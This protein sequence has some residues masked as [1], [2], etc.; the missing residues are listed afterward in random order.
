MKTDLFQLEILP[1]DR[2]VEHEVF[3]V[4]RME[5]ILARLQEEKKLVNPILVAPMPDGRYLQLDG[6]NR[7]SAFRTL[8]IP[9]IAAQIVDYGNDE[10]VKLF[11]WMHLYRITTSE[12]FASLRSAQVTTGHPAHIQIPEFE[13]GWVATVQP[14]P[15]L[16]TGAQSA[17]S[18]SVLED[19]SD[20]EKAQTILG[21]VQAYE[22]AGIVRERVPDHL[23]TD[24]LAQYTLAHA[25]THGSILFPR[26]TKKHIIA[27][28]KDGGLLPAGI[29]RHVVK[30]RCLN[31]SVPI[32]L[33]AENLSLEEKNTRFDTL[34]SSRAVRRYEEPVVYIE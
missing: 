29:T 6:M 4:Q 25:D 26:F 13:N 16:S 24:A 12:L 17:P 28:V 15:D 21:L 8:N 27:L 18:I 19:R 34:L 14:F 30:N 23:S 2:I 11:S 31:V 33:M 20:K 3:D 7:L 1:I 32:A 5:P 22:S 9:A 10:Q